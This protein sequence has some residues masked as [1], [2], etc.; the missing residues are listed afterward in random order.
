MVMRDEYVIVLKDVSLRSVVAVA[1]NG[2]YEMMSQPCSVNII[3]E[4]EKECLRC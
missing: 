4:Y 1:K 2:S 3:Q